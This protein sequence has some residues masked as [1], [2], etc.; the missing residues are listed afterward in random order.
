MQQI[1]IENKQKLSCYS[2]KKQ[3]SEYF[4]KSQFKNSIRPDS[5]EKN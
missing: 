5:A 4:T 3:K 1:M 2:R